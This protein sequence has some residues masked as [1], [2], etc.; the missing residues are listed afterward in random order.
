[1]SLLLAGFWSNFA[2]D[3]LKNSNGFHQRRCGL[4]AKKQTG[5]R[6][7]GVPNVLHRF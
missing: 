7:G 2:T 4:G 1:M 6:G 5:S 3:F